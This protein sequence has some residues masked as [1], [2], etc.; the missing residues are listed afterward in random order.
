VHFDQSLRAAVLVGPEKVVTGAEALLSKFDSPGAMRGDRQIQLRIHLVEASQEPASGSVPPEIGPAVEQMKKSFA[1]KG[2]RHVETLTAIA[3]DG[4]T[5]S[6][7]IAA[8]GPNP[9]KYNFRVQ[10]SSVLEDGKT[11]A[12]KNFS[13]VAHV[14]VPGT[15]Q[16]TDTSIQTDLTIQQGQKLVV[17]KLSSPNVQ[18]A[19]FLIVTADVL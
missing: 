16:M 15:N 13:F 9:T 8:I 10:S 5:S 1:Y 11:V 4:V 6:G 3:K 19:L 12:L 7:H 17:G 18:N 14:P 2:Y